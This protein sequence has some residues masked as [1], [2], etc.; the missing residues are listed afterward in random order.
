MPTN[1]TNKKQTATAEVGQLSCMPR[2]Q[3]SARRSGV[4]SRLKRIIRQLE[5]IELGLGDLADEL[6]ELCRRHPELGELNGN[7]RR[8]SAVRRHSET[9]ALAL[10]ER[11]AL[12]VQL[13]W[14]NDGRAR[15]WI[16]GHELELSRKLG[17][18]LECLKRDDSD[19]DDFVAWKPRAEV[20]AWFQKA[21]PEGMEDHQLDNLVWRL[22]E[23]LRLQAGLH[24]EFV[25][26]N[27]ERGLRF[28][29]KRPGG[30]WLLNVG[31]AP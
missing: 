21:E 1:H 11:G 2:T 24:H 3:R 27:R 4:T 23:E 18:L 16:D 6:A 8:H 12:E 19:S 29:L 9:M 20:L 13:E 5:N 25:Q 31:L 30:K 15:V 10:A 7:S 17:L 14:L 28:A 26:V 22:R